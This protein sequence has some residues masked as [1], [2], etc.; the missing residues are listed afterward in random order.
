M[1]YRE[2]RDAAA[3]SEHLIPSAPLFPQLL[4]PLNSGTQATA[5]KEASPTGSDVL[6]LPTLPPPSLPH[7]APNPIFRGFHDAS[8]SGLLGVIVP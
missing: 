7:P 2:S 6:T 8:P 5:E 3:G 1:S 4:K